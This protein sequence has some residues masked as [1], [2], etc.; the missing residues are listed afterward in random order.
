[1][2][3]CA[4]SS[5]PTVDAALDVAARDL[6]AHDAAQPDVASDLLADTSTDTSTGDAS[7]ADI[8]L[9]LAEARDV[10]DKN[11]ATAKRCARCHQNVAGGNAMRDEKKRPIAQY[12]LWRASPMANAGRDPIWRA[13]VA[14]EVENTPSKKV[15]IEETCMRCHTPMAY[16]QNVKDGDPPVAMSL[17]SGD[18]ARAQMALDGVSCTACHQIEPDKLG[19]TASFSGHYVIGDKN[20]AYGPHENLS[21]ESMKVL[22]GFNLETGK[23]ILQANLCGSC[24]TL[25][26]NPLKADGSSASAAPFP[27]QTPY[28][29]W[30]NSVF[31]TEAATP[32]A[33]ATTCQ[34]CHMPTTSED[35]VP[36]K[37][38][39]ATNTNGSDFPLDRVPERSPYG[40]HL[41]VG[42]NTLLPTLL[43]RFR[44]E[45]SPNASKAAFDAYIGEVRKLLTQ[46]TAA[47]TIGQVA[48]NG[49]EL[50][51]SVKLEN[52]AGHKLPTAYPARRVILSVEVLAANTVIWASG[53]FDSSGKLVKA[54]KTIQP[55]EKR[56][57]PTAPH[58]ARID[59][60]DQVQ[61]Y[62]SILA[63]SAGKP[64]FHLL[65]ATQY[66]KDNRLLPKG[67]KSDHPDIN[68]I[69]P[70][71]I[72][73]DTDFVAG[74]DS[75]R[76]VAKLPSGQTGPLT[77]RATLWHQPLSWRFVDELFASRA[78]EVLVLERMLS[79]TGLQ[80]EKIVSAEVTVP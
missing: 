48:K 59:Q 58:R 7:S 78:P 66:L 35:G 45:L 30:R 40:R 29:E 77:V 76:Y 53:R 49:D 67:W 11:F 34:G 4:E 41:F 17:L 9:P 65:R 24:H 33:E 56:G 27:E 21:P 75:V 39:V 50:T 23:H 72:G 12:D 74:G 70:R 5:Q 52:L 25:F 22:S 63:D 42:A 69:A 71:G 55:F 38:Q 73:T 36:I 61:I 3:A 60:Q 15:T 19:T 20:V 57:G 51:V 8:R 26:T 62:Q 37:T 32:A 46:K 64:T 1:M 2:L 79:Q 14:A 16:T 31:S 80:P 47:L 43:D 54:D 18:T 68:Q 28:L 10:F 6:V 44:D 13:A